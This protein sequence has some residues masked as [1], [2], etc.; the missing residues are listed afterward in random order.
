M[1]SLSRLYPFKFFKGCL[2]KNL[3]SPLLNT[4][5]QIQGEKAY[6]PQGQKYGQK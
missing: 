2:P 5:S 6:P 4:L 1:V 3:L